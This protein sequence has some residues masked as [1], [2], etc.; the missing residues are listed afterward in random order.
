MPDYDMSIHT[1]ADAMAWAKLF[2]EKNPDCGLDEGVMVGWFANAMMA[3]HDHLTGQAPVV[4]PDG[5]AFFVGE[6]TA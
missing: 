2:C 4:L 6:R 5:S 3:M 1:N